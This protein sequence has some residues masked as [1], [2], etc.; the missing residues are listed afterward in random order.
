M[1]TTEEQRQNFEKHLQRTIDRAAIRKGLNEGLP[2]KEIKKRVRNNHNRDLPHRL[3]NELV[4]VNPE[5]DKIMEDLQKKVENEFPGV[6]LVLLGSA[7]HGG[8]ELRKAL[9]PDAAPFSDLDIGIIYDPRIPFYDQDSTK[10]LE[11]LKKETPVSICDTFNPTRMQVPSLRDKSDATTLLY[12]IATD[13][14]AIKLGKDIMYFLP[15]YPPNIN[16]K[17]QELI[18]KALK[19]IGQRNPYEWRVVREILID[20]WIIFHALQDKHRAIGQEPN[21]YSPDQDKFISDPRDQSYSTNTTTEIT[22][23]FED[24]INSTSPY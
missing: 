15:S 13:P 24:L 21:P 14:Q 23:A 4:V 3:V 6:Y 18:F 12:Q 7:A 17:N 5:A 16:R 19:E 11:L 1:D 10:I 20:R 22:K 2:L 9:R 8:A